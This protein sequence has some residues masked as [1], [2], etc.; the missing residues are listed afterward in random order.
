VNINLQRGDIVLI[1]FPFTDLSGSKRRPAIVLADYPPDMVVAFI[2]SVI[3]TIIE[4]SDVILEPSS[5]FFA[6]T[7]LKK[8]S[9][10]RLRKLA[11]LEQSLITRLL[12]QLDPKLLKDVDQALINGLGIDTVQLVHNE[13][14]E[15]M[16][17]L[18]EQGET[19]VITHIQAKS[20]N[21]PT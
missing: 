6:A 11:T 12:G 19:A 2:S 1:R 17:L 20:Q 4:P 14:Q 21:K 8:A 13:Y 16:R 18:K 5:P 7:G 3:P 9:L 15:L 10:I